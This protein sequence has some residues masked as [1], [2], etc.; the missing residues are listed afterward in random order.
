MDFRIYRGQICTAKH[1]R[2]GSPDQNV[3]FPPRRS[4]SH[5]IFCVCDLCFL[6]LSSTICRN[7]SLQFHAAAAAGVRRSHFWRS[8]WY[9]P[10]HFCASWVPWLF[11]TFKIPPYHLSD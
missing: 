9:G 10:F 1:I 4:V 6:Y 3:Q 8:R 7:G 5:L 2:Q 11:C